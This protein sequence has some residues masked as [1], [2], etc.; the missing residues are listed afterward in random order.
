MTTKTTTTKEQ[1]LWGSLTIYASNDN[2]IIFMT[3]DYVFGVTSERGLDTIA[4]GKSFK[5]I[6]AALKYVD[7]RIKADN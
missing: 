4:N 7:E 1:R 6:E 2:Y 3:D 5:T